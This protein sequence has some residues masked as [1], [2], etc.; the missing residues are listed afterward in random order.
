VDIQLQVTRKIER[1]ESVCARIVESTQGDEIRGHV[2]EGVGHGIPVAKPLRDCKRVGSLGIRGLPVSGAEL[3][4]PKVQGNACHRAVGPEQA[5][6]RESVT[7]ARSSTRGVARR[8]PSEGEHLEY[9]AL[10]HG[11]SE[12]TALVQRFAQVLLALPTSTNED[13]RLPHEA[14]GAGGPKSVPKRSEP[15]QGQPSGGQRDT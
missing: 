12:R 9:D 7:E 14:Q 4:L 11:I 1:L 10:Q 3:N 15:Y 2:T 13:E 8:R 5:I 6:D